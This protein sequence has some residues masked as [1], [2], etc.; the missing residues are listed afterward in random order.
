MAKQKEKFAKYVEETSECKDGTKLDRVMEASLR[1]GYAKGIMDKFLND[2][3]YDHKPSQTELFFAICQMANGIELIAQ[4][5]GKSIYDVINL[6][7]TKL[8][9][10]DKPKPLT[11]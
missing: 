7:M 10:E 1:I 9:N 4:Q 3:L 6:E 5:Y 11:S 2:V 8:E